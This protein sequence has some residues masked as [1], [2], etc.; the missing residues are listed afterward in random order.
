MDPQPS[1][2]GAFA[3]ELRNALSPARAAL[4]LLQRREAANESLQPAL[5]TMEKSIA[6]TLQAIDRFVDAVRIFDGSVKL[7]I[8]PHHL[9]S[10]VERAC[11]LA[12]AMLAERGHR[13]ELNPGSNDA[14]VNGDS[15]RL[16]QVL[17]QLIE[18]ASLNAPDGGTIDV[19]ARA[20]EHTVA[21]VVRHPSPRLDDFDPARALESLRIPARTQGIALATAR[22]LMEL[23]GGALTARVDGASGRA[24]FVMSL[25][26]APAGSDT[27]YSQEPQRSNAWARA[28][29]ANTNHSGRMP[30]RILLVDDN[31]A[32]RDIYREALE[33]LGYNVTLAANGEEALHV[34]EH[35]VPEVA[36]IDVHLP[37]LNGYQ[38][39]RALRARHP[40]SGI[41]LVLLSG[42]TLDDD[43]V[44]LSKNAG[45]DHCVDKGAGPKAIDALLRQ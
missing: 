3:H 10:I 17:A 31:Q 24:E 27:T 29:T 7:D 39:A 34:V 23:Q 37:T 14:F 13:V 12:R 15:A 43:M 33:E 1:L 25:M 2:P 20:D 16:P 32:V 26:R 45:F 28:H 35:A 44:R 40:S 5:R 36:L 19:S 22:R 18:N 38:L 41:K 4:E 11:E 8:G 9:G 21:L 30:Q 42:M 6:A